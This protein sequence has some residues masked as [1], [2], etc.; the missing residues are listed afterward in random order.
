MMSAV[1]D[2]STLLKTMEPVHHPGTF[3]FTSIKPGTSVDPTII[4]ASIREAEGLSVVMTEADATRLHLPVLFRCAWITLSVHSDLQAV[5]LT[6]AFATALGDARISCNVVAGANHDHI[7]VPHAS[8]ARA[9]N[10]LRALQV[11]ASI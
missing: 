3:V 4:L 10:V 1:S 9:M 6:A 7:F 2:L 8:S 11:Q 5:G